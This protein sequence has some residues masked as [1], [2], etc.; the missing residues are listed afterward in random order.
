MKR[1]I[2]L[3]DEDSEFMV[4]KLDQMNFTS[5]DVSKVVSCFSSMDYN[6][7]VIKFSEFDLNVN[8]QGVYILYQSSEAEG[9]FYK[10]YIED[11]IF[12]LEKQGAI[13]L[14]GYELLKAHHN[15][16]YMEMMR[17]Q[18]T[19]NSLKTVSS[20]CYGSW[21]DAKNYNSHFPVVI[22]RISTTSGE[23][24]YLA[25][26]RKEYL[27]NIKK[28]GRMIV[29]MSLKNFIL[30][31]CK[32]ITKKIIK[33]LLPV[34]SKYVTYNTVPISSP[35]VVQNFVEGL[36]GDY[37]VLIYGEKYYTLYR[38]N[39]KNDFRASGSGRFFEVPQQE[40][41]GLLDFAKKI[42]SQI[43]FPIFGLDIGFDGKSYHL[44]EFQMIYLGTFCLQC[45]KF[46]HEFHD[47]KWLKYEG[48]SILEE[49]FSRAINLHIVKF[50]GK[51]EPEYL[52]I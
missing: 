19:D 31:S 12:F 51:T 35:I 34:R 18:F 13:V 20:F 2:I 7:S 4:S 42:I 52:N 21:V 36:S 38:K 30:V 39:R 17:S 11:L 46:Y 43:D 47:G 48:V 22:K 32:N 41:E 29:A 50:E 25:H 5:M 14:P 8:Y 3:T 10:N 16:V 44:L 40:Q 6:V 45:A 9:S 37:K 24:V 1:L 28:A 27:K 49:E 15:K 33:A 23:G 26:N